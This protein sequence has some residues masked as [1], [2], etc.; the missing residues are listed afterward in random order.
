MCHFFNALL[1]SDR[2]DIKDAPGDRGAKGG[3][4][5]FGTRPAQTQ[6]HPVRNISGKDAIMNR[7]YGRN[8]REAT[9]PANAISEISIFW[10]MIITVLV[11][12]AGMLKGMVW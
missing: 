3:R 5:S 12:V 2:C 11:V 9:A 6:A 4:L 8:S 1:W 7:D 10:G